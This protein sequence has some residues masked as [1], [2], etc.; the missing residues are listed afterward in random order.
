MALLPVWIIG[1]WTLLGAGVVA[2]LHCGDQRRQRERDQEWAQR[3]EEAVAHRVEAVKAAKRYPS[4][5]TLLLVHEAN[6]AVRLV[7][8]AAAQDEWR[9]RELASRIGEAR[10]ARVALSRTPLAVV[11]FQ[12]YASERAARQ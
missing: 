11:G 3:R 9:V 6:L 1:G 4:E 12:Q 10:A 2:L 7:D 5:V 8:A